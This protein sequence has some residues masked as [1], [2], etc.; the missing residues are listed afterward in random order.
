MES[1]ISLT[2]TRDVSSHAKLTDAD[3]VT[4]GQTDHYNINSMMYKKLELSR[5]HTP[6]AACR[7]VLQYTGH[8]VT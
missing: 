6:C 8:S 4:D 1:T 3:P 2:M 7:A 5:A